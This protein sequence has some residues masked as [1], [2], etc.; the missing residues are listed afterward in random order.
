VRDS[1]LDAGVAFEPVGLRGSILSP[2]ADAAALR[3]FHRLMRLHQ[4]DVAHAHGA[5]AGAL[6]RLVAARAGLP[7][8]YTPHCFA[9]ISNR[10]REVRAPRAREALAAGIER[11]LAPLTEKIICVSQYEWEEAANK[12]IGPGLRTMIHSGI[13]VSRSATPDPRMVAWRGDGLLVGAVCTLRAQKG[14]R[15]LVEAVS[16][17]GEAHP[18]LRFAIVGEGPER[19][20]LERMIVA[21]GLEHRLRLFEFGGTVEPHLMALDAFVLPSLYES[22]PLGVLEAMAF[23]LPVVAS[24]VGGIPEMVRDGE[25]GYLIPPGDPPALRDA[26]IRMADD[27]A[28]RERMGRRGRA[29]VDESFRYEDMVSAVEALY[30]EVDA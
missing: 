12:G 14:L 21:R 4:F 7:V 13:E 3:G 6:L 11:A 15:N 26:V 19:D 20:S 25:T 1:M 18:Q 17:L 2:R 8:M 16:L 9:F 30:I 27:P 29:V 10:H 24:N 5:K 28:G 22:L 23:G